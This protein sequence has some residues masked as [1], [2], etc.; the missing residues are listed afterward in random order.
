MARMKKNKPG[1][2]RRQKEAASKAK[3]QQAPAPVESAE[4]GRPGGERPAKKQKFERGAAR[5]PPEPSHAS[6]DAH[7]AGQE[8]GEQGNEIPGLKR[9]LDPPATVPTR[10]KP[11][12]TPTRPAKPPLTSLHPQSPHPATATEQLQQPSLRA[13]FATSLSKTYDAVS[14]SIISSSPIRKKVSKILSHIS[15]PTAKKLP[16]VI[17]TAKAAVASKAISIAEI[18]KREIANGGGV[19]F[20]YSGVEGV[21]SEWVSK[22]RGNKAEGEKAETKSGDT[23]DGEGAIELEVPVSNVT[24]A[25]EEGIDGGEEEEEEEAFENMRGL[26]TASQPMQEHPSVIEHE[27]RKKVRA[28]PVLTIYLSRSQIGEL[29]KEY[30]EQ[31]N[32][33]M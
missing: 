4:D 21:L 3:Q 12:R 32:L 20:Q 25:T 5:A 1:G 9:G 18:S 28:V 29:K 7:D 16:L 30:G 31:T 19:W 10:P 13:S 2:A 23:G 24:E 33:K 11:S 15:S 14:L 27:L 17:L 6:H 22:G 8:T 26:P